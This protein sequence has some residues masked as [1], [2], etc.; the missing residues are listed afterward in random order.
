MAKYLRGDNEDGL[1]ATLYFFIGALDSREI[2]RALELCD[3]EFILEKKDKYGMSALHHACESNELCAKK[4]IA[5]ADEEQLHEADHDGRTPLHCACEAGFKEVVWSLID[6]GVALDDVDVDGMSPLHISLDAKHEAV[7]LSILRLPAGRSGRMETAIDNAGRTPLHCG[8]NAKLEL[9]V[10]ALLM[11]EVPVDVADKKGKTALFLASETG[12]ETLA[13]KLLSLGASHVASCNETDMMVLHHAAKQGLCAVVEELLKARAHSELEIDGLNKD[14]E[15][16]FLLACEAGMAHVSKVLADAGAKRDL[17]DLQDHN[18]LHKGA[19]GGHV[20]VVKLL[21]EGGLDVEGVSH[22]GGRGRRALHYAAWYGRGPVAEALLTAKA[23]C[24]AV[25]GTG[26]KAIHL[27]ARN[28]HASVVQHLLHAGA[29]GLLPNDE[30]QSA[31]FLARKHK[32][33]NVAMVLLEAGVPDEQV[34]SR[35]A[36]SDGSDSDRDEGIEVAPKPSLF[37]S[38]WRAGGDGW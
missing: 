18:G 7:A 14:G 2:V 36:E 34:F 11:A 37:S 30:G 31:M 26:M 3:D 16:A 6:R 38:F 27:A 24:E 12:Q 13:L 10:N 1:N 4:L 20:E 29:S 8:V 33:E 22:D 21:L 25:D 32:K 28:G 35:P 15:S 23:D 19:I 5:I 9:A 17:V